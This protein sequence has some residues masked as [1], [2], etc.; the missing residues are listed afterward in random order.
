MALTWKPEEEFAALAEGQIPDGC[1]AYAK[2]LE[3]GSVA[4]YQ[5]KDEIGRAHV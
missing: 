1:K 4:Q 3:Q 5:G 2:L